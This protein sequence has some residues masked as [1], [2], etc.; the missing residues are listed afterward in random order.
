[1][2]QKDIT[3][4]MTVDLICMGMASRVIAAENSVCTV[5]DAAGRTVVAVR[6]H[7]RKG[8]P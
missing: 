2:S 4:E 1:M 3:A 8:R 7:Q 6:A 5:N